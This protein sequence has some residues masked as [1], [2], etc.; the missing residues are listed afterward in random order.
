VSY[1]DY[2][3][4][5]RHYVHYYQTQEKVDFN[6]ESG[7]QQLTDFRKRALDTVVNYAYI[8]E[9]AQ[10]HNISVGD[11]EVND[12]IALLRDQNR[13]GSNDQVFADVL[14]EYWGWSVP[15]FKRELKQQILAQKVVA[16]LDTD[17]QGRAKT[18][19]ARVKAG[20]DFATLAQQLS[21]DKGTAANGG[22]YGFDIDKSTRDL[23]PQVIDEL[24][25]LQVGQ[26]SG[27]ISTSTGLEILKLDSVNGTKVRASHI[28]L[29][30]KSID[31]YL[32]PIRA[33]EK[34]T[35][36]IHP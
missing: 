14:K 28:V 27:L 23:P 3:F 15:D 4:E 32:A 17:T 11:Q 33:K 8:K 6:G 9:L 7:K 29:N 1:E 18:A 12:V 2:L 10:Q 20:E 22:Q 35:T 36:F 25:K 30:F 31:Q 26:T 19:L 21:D 5:L 16:A 13:L 34:P 24:F